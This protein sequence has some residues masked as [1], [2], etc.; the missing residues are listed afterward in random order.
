MATFSDEPA[1]PCFGPPDPRECADRLADLRR[2][3]QQANNINRRQHDSAVHGELLRL[4]RERRADRP[5]LD[6]FDLVSDPRGGEVLIVPNELVIRARA[7]DD[8]QVQR[9]LAAYDLHPEFVECL[10]NRI[11]VLRVPDT[12]GPRLAELAGALR[13][14][15]VPAGLNYVTPM[16]IVMKGLGGPEPSAGPAPQRPPAGPGEPLK[17]AVVDTGIAAKPRDDGWLDGLVQPDNIDPLNELP[18][19]PDQFLDFGAGHGTF[20]AGIVQQVAPAADIAVYRALDSDGIGSKVR[21]ATAM[22]RAAR[23]GAQIINLSLGLEA[24]EDRPPLALQVA[25]EMIDEIAAETG[26]EVLVIAAAGNFGNDRPCWPAAFSEVVAVGALTQALEPADW[27]SRGYWVDCSTIGE[28][29]RS[30]YVEGEESPKIDPTPDRFGPSAWAL[31]SGTSFAAPQVAGAV[32][33]IAQER[34]AGPRAA[35]RIL[36]DGAREIPGYGRGV[37]ILPGV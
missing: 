33:Q 31:W 23:E 36:L 28:G 3:Y 7:L 30:T 20:A 37:E 4:L 8:Q 10:D 22:V 25:L 32:A 21:L 9:M 1:Q 27:S 12:D 5:D 15:G 14:R 18:S 17:V 29:V 34:G 24:L 11:A 6:Q 13:A 26:R 16:G 19:P 35:L 2:I